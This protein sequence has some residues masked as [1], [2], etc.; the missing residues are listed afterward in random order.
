MDNIVN[1]YKKIGHSFFILLVCLVS[2]LIFIFALNSFLKIFN[3][4]TLIFYCFIL[5]FIFIIFYKI[6]FL[7]KKFFIDFNTKMI[8]VLNIFLILISFSLLYL[9][10]I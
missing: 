6:L 8:I 10:F 9:N 1:F 5:S 4:F 2:S 3:F 7:D